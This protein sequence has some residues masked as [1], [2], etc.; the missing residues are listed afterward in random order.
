MEYKYT[1][2]HFVDLPIFSLTKNFAMEFFKDCVSWVE[3]PVLDFNRAKA[4]YQSIFDYEMPEMEM[5]P[6][7][8]GTLLHNREEGGIGGAICH[9]EGYVPAGS[10]G[11]RLYLNGGADLNNVLNQV[12]AAG[13]KITMPK[14]EIAPGMGNMAFFDDTEGNNIGLYSAG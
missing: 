8:M 14:V 11:P 6:V 2:K 7:K 3:I 9:G 1:Y 10:N 5:G 12:E 4:F 13:G